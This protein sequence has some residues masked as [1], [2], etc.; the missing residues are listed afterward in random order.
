LLVT[1]IIFIRQATFLYLL[2]YSRSPLQIA[3]ECEDKL[4]Q[5]QVDTYQCVAYNYSFEAG[6]LEIMTLLLFILTANELL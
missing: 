1:Q 3:A 5:V 4:H 6:S 2:Y